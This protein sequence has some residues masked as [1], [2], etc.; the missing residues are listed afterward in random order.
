MLAKP[1]FETTAF[2]RMGYYNMYQDNSFSQ[3]EIENPVEFVKKLQILYVL[4]N[5]Q[6]K[7]AVFINEISLEKNQNKIF[8]IVARAPSND[9]AKKKIQ[10]L[11]LKIQQDH[12]RRIELIQK[13]LQKYKD[14][15]LD[16]LKDIRL[17]RLSSVNKELAQKEKSVLKLLKSTIE[18]KSLLLSH[19]NLIL[20]DLNKRKNKLITREFL[21]KD[22]LQSIAGQSFEKD[23]FKNTEIIGKILQND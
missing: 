6:K 5:K 11:V 9:K 18:N 21:L 20:S 16:E 13:K 12:K 14:E 4:K 10:D 2:L 22:R 7:E 8:K 3:I 1:V 17:N 19:Y 23:N 15:L